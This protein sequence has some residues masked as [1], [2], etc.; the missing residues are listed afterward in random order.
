MTF[1]GTGTSVGVP[2]I[3]CDCAV[4][5][6]DEPRNKRSR[7]SVVV[8]TGEVTVLVDSGPDLR[9]QALRENLREIDAVIYTHGHVDHVVGF[10]ELRAFCWRRTEP[11]PLHAT[12]G[13]MEVLQRMFGWAF[14]PEQQVAGYVRPDARWITGPFSY[15]DL[16]ITPL[17]VEHASVETVGFLF[18]VEGKRSLAYLPDVKRIPEATLELLRGVDVLVVD[19]LRSAPHPTHFSL[20][21][22]LATAAETGAAEVW[23]TH[24]SHEYDA[25]SCGLEIPDNV[26]LAW[27]GLT[28]SL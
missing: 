25:R 1:L 27:D 6:S 9:Q 20:G 26:R 2:V 21:D 4:C 24:L 12:A 14:F 3:G 15:G 22:A 23:L 13:C 7:S 17:P 18:G 5:L 16:R 11:L 8:R 10:D 28:V 19:A